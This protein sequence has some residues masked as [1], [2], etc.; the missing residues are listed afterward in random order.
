M[1]KSALRRAAGMLKYKALYCWP[2]KFKQA[3]AE[4]LREQFR[5]R[6]FELPQLPAPDSVEVEIHMLCGKKQLDMGIWSSWSILRFLRN[7]VLY[8]HSDGTLTDEDACL[9][10]KIIPSTILISKKEADDRVESEISIRWPL[11]YEW[12]CSYRASPQVVDVHLFGETDRLIVMDSDI[13][14]FQA[15]MELQHWVTAPEPVFRWQKDV[16]NRYIAD[17]ELLNEITGLSL[18]EAFN[19]GFCLIP[20]FRE[21]YFDHLEKVLKFLKADGRVNV[22]RYW[23]PQTLGAMCAALDPHAKPLPSSYAL[24]LGR[25]LN[26]MVLRHYVGIPCVRWRYFAEGLPRLLTAIEKQL[27]D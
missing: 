17:I 10:Q 5:P 13:L 19:A 11:L 25:T 23:S 18:P 24:T 26:D 1:S 16:G 4:K 6:A 2:Y 27:T 14:C 15:P 12:R 8:V 21:K 20:R 22:H 9:W 3:R 7:A